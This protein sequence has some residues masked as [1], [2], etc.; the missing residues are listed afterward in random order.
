M[1]KWTFGNTKSILNLKITLSENYL[2]EKLILKMQ[3]KPLKN[4]TNKNFTLF[5]VPLLF[6][7]QVALNVRGRI[8]S[9]S[10]LTQE[11]VLLLQNIQEQTTFPFQFDPPGA[12]RRTVPV[13][14][15]NFCYLRLHIQLLNDSLHGL[16]PSV[17]N[18]ESYSVF[19]TIIK[20]LKPS[21]V[22]TIATVIKI[23]NSLPA[24]CSFQ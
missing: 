13:K 16:D 20:I 1:T 14:R 7:K 18:A 17:T 2:W 21:S 3:K 12:F 24:A 19:K 4:F 8:P 6:P 9:D 22:P 11:T 5:D 15:I 23:L 10:S